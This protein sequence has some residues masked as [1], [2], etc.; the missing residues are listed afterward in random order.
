MT[1]T[2]ISNDRRWLIL[3]VILS[4][5]FMAILDVFIVNVT[6]PSLRDDL[7]A[8][9]AAVQ[10]VVDGYA[11][12]FATALITG[13]RLGDVIGRR[14]AFRIGVGAFTFSSALCGAAPTPTL[15]VAARA[16]QGLSCAL[17]MPQVLSIIQVEFAPHERR[18]CLAIMGGVQGAASVCGQLVGGALIGLDVLGLG[19]RTVFLINVPVG[20]AAVVAAGVIVPESRS[21][22]ARRLDLPGVALGALV[23]LLVVF[24]I[25]EGRAAGWPWWVPTA[26]VAAVPVAIAWVAHERGLTA[27]GGAPLVDLSLFAV[28]GYR[29]GLG[30][31]LVFYTGLTCVF[32]LLGLYLQEGLALSPLQ[33]GLAFTPLAVPFVAATLIAPRYFARFGDRLIAFGSAV[34]AL[35]A[36]GVAIGVAAT[37][38]TG[39]T[40]AL[41][42]GLSIV[43]I[44]PGIVVPGVINAVL[45]SV[46]P[47]SAGSASGVLTTAQQIGN[48][49]GVAIAGALFFGALGDGV[50]ARAYDRA[51]AIG[52]AW[53]VATAALS[54]VLALRVAARP[55]RDASGA[56]TVS[57]AMAVAKPHS[58]V[59]RR[60]A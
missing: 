14:R 60:A 33:S 32:F 47:E 2:Q 19:W 13:G 28:R 52:L 39:V 40:P 45:R 53:S 5:T 44:G 37:H 46:P 12:A 36:G 54:T 51:F 3:P 7:G 50:G 6:S 17:M 26:L 59:A 31:A 57:P 8:S 11:L 35:A 21:P 1:S 18:R 15:L 56:D 10:W 22:S 20:V 9:A 38:P 29:L 30:L 42:V 48:A 55:A 25:V 41:I 49:L 23:A 58:E 43:C 16:A 27:R 4:A 24:P 34:M